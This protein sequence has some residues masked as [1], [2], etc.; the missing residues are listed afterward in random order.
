MRHILFHAQT[1]GAEIFLLQSYRV[2]E[3]SESLLLVSQILLERQSELYARVF[4]CTLLVE[5]DLCALLHE[6]RLLVEIVNISLAVA[7][8]LLVDCCVERRQIL[9]VYVLAVVLEQHREHLFIQCLVPCVAVV[10]K[11]VVHLQRVF[12]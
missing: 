3:C 12:L 5:V 11:L 9:L 10:L 1:C 6:N 7:L 2:A 8:E 4:L